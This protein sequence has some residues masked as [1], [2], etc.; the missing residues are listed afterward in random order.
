L[1]R[2][3][4]AELSAEGRQSSHPGKGLAG[5]AASLNCG[6]C[7]AAC[8]DRRSAP[9]R[10]CGVETISTRAPFVRPGEGLCEAAGPRSD[11]PGDEASAGANGSGSSRGPTLSE[12]HSE[13]STPSMSKTRAAGNLV[14][15]A[16]LA[17]SME[18][19]SYRKWMEETTRTRSNIGEAARKFQEMGLV[20]YDRGRFRILN[21]AAMERMA[22]E[23]YAVARDEYDG[24]YQNSPDQG[25]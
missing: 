1:G 2:E 12:T 25:T 22:C 10:V 20:S 6:A 19:K 23:C 13:T 18:M 3:K 8:D 15:T 17:I 16:S 9:A 21:R 5:G 14:M 24:L 4:G 7:A 11:G